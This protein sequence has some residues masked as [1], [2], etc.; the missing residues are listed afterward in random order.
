M[1]YLQ[2]I[3]TH[4]YFCDGKDAPEDMVKEAIRL[5]FNAL[6]FSA[7]SASYY[8]NYPLPPGGTENY[9]KEINRYN[10]KRNVPKS[11]GH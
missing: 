7:H 8:S 1:Q 10:T 3:H 6:G 2:N 4:T 9:I 11:Q 5:G